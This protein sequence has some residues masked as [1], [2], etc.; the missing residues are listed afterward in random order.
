MPIYEYKS[1][2]KGCGYCHQI[3]E[4]VQR[5]SEHPL[6]KCPRCQAPVIRLPSRFFACILET[7]AEVTRTESTIQNYEREG[8]WSHAA[9]IADKAGL[10]ERAREDYKKAGY[11]M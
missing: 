10:D 11:D 5:M 8:M 2:G 4:V 6:V 9:E 7:P 1:A 3:F